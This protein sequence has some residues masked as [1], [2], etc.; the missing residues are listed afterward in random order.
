ML[1]EAIYFDGKS[2][3]SYQISGTFQEARREIS[4]SH[5]DKTL[6]IL[7]DFDCTFEPINNELTI[8]VKDCAA[9]LVIS[10]TQLIKAIGRQKPQSWNKNLYHKLIDGGMGLHVFIVFLILSLILFVN[11][12]VLPAAAEKAVVLVPDSYGKSL[13]NTFFKNYK[14]HNNIDE[15]KI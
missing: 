12:Y 10:D 1:F 3:I 9:Q 5:K 2:A 14:K 13:G 11:F 4:F 15:E 7:L 8:H 6:R